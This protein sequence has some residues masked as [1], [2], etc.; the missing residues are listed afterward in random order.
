MQEAIPGHDVLRVRADNPGPFTL[1]GTNT[2]VVGRDPAWVVDPGP[3][4]PAHV[5]AVLAAVAERGGAQGIVLTHDHADHVE[6]AGHVAAELGVNLRARVER[7]VQATLEVGTARHLLPG[8]DRRVV[9]GER[10]GR[11]CVVEGTINGAGNAA[12]NGLN[13]ND[14]ANMLNGMG[15]KDTLWGGLGADIL[16]GGSLRLDKDANVGIGGTFTNN[17]TITYSPVTGAEFARTFLAPL[18]PADLGPPAAP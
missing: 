10:A 1:S 3:A 7:L 12:N 15:G 5:D 14:A 16:T 13:G 11:T 2:W 6:A 9:L 8:C 4:L 17:P 18:P